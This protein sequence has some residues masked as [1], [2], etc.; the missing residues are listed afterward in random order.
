[1]SGKIMECTKTQ[2]YRLDFGTDG[3]LYTVTFTGNIPQAELKNF[4]LP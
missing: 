3:K 1:M 2:N 4:F